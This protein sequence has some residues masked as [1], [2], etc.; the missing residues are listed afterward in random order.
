MLGPCLVL[1][2]YT[3]EKGRLGLLI[4]LRTLERKEGS[5]RHSNQTVGLLHF[6]QRKRGNRLFSKS[7]S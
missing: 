6:G 2:S 7:V 1:S 5:P 3:Q 4:Q